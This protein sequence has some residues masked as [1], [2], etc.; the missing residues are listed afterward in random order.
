[1]VK[2]KV[3]TVYQVVKQANLVV[4]LR[5]PRKLSLAQP[6]LMEGLHFWTRQRVR[7]QVLN[8]LSTY[9]PLAITIINLTYFANY[10]YL[11][12]Y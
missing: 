7:N 9:I 1:V 5:T 8:D 12:I 11:F 10:Y 2:T 6:I 4:E 3:E